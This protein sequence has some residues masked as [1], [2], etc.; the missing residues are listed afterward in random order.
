[1]GAEVSAHL[2]AHGNRRAVAVTDLTDRLGK[3][4]IQG[5]LAARI[6]ARILADAHRV[7]DAMPLLFFQRQ[8]R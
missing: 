8:L 1:M 6:L 3:I 4:D 2:T 5:P 7:L